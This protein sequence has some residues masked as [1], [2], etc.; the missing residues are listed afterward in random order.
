MGRIAR[1]IRLYF[2]RRAKA[3]RKLILKNH[4]SHF[5]FAR[6]SASEVD[7]RRLESL[8]RKKFAL[9]LSL[10]L[11]S[12]VGVSLVVP[13]FVT[14]WAG[15]VFHVVAARPLMA[16]IQLWLM[17][18]GAQSALWV[19]SITYTVATAS[20]VMKTSAFR[21]QHVGVAVFSL[22]IPGAAI[23]IFTL[24]EGGSP[25]LPPA[26]LGPYRIVNQAVVGITGMV[27]AGLA[28]LGMYLVCSVWQSE[29][30][31]KDVSGE[32]VARYLE[33]RESAVRLLFV[34]GVVMAGAIVAE[35]AMCNAVN[36]ENGKDYFPP[37]YVIVFG[38][39]YSLLLMGA[40][41][42]VYSV[43]VTTG[44]RLREAIVGQPPTSS[45]DF[46]VWQE[47]RSA[48][49]GAFGLSWNGLAALGPVFSVLL[50]LFSGWVTTLLGTKS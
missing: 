38:A 17:L 34:A 40:Y 3:R 22:A 19:A 46:K 13:L 50:P 18:L 49:D 1:A 12:L 9:V 20:R 44:A 35:G 23:I 15:G 2:R 25:G 30:E 33:L 41:A 42:P 37:E 28:V 24:L 5:R 16:K 8:S 31:V 6:F 27:V 32:K 48:V 26:T 11:L 21:F 45:A 47:S 4:V 39:V 14:G 43:F 36:A 10:V 29:C 7:M